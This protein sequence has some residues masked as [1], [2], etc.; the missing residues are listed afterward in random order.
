M[1]TLERHLSHDWV[2]GTKTW[3]MEAVKVILESNL[4]FVTLIFK[5]FDYFSMKIC[6]LSLCFLL[7]RRT[8]L[9]VWIFIII[10]SCK[11]D[12]WSCYFAGRIKF[13]L[14]VKKY[15]GVVNVF[16]S[17]RKLNYMTV[18]SMWRSRLCRFKDNSNY[19]KKK[20]C[21]KKSRK[22]LLPPPGP[23]YLYFSWL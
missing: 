12:N 22:N 10:I 23:L 18:D 6:I 14:N 7:Y 20:K 15:P 17:K 8:A 21:L 4:F 2:R 1:R 19:K 3:F 11:L 9:L 16:S 13:L 5:V